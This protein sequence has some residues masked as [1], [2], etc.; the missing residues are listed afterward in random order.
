MTAIRVS[1]ECTRLEGGDGVRTLPPSLF[2]WSQ[3]QGKDEARPSGPP[4]WLFGQA[5]IVTWLQSGDR[6][7]M[8]IRTVV[9]EW[10]CKA[11]LPLCNAV[12]LCLTGTRLANSAGSARIKHGVIDSYGHS[13]FKR[14]EISTVRP[15]SPHCGAAS[16]DA[17]DRQSLVAHRLRS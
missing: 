14:G 13:P 4:Q 10:S 9:I 8:D 3:P 6:S 12:R 17:A 5:L 7:L 15:A 11:A 16:R 1:A 2:V